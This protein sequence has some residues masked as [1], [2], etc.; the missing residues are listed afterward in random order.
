LPA[1]AGFVECDCLQVE[2]RGELLG[3]RQL[4]PD[5]ELPVLGGKVLGG[6]VLSGKVSA[7]RAR[8][9]I[10]RAASPVTRLAAAVEPA[11]GDVPMPIV[12]VDARI[13]SRDCLV[14]TCGI[15]GAR[16]NASG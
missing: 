5:C 7:A 10:T 15:V 6:K 2:E 4:P 3:R 9:S 16:G 14:P 13:R 1:D 11:G 8:S 12:L